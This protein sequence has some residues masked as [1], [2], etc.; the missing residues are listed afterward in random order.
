MNEK[1]LH[2]PFLILTIAI[3]MAFLL[4][5]MA[6]KSMFFDGITYA[7]I[8]RNLANGEGTFWFLRYTDSFDAQFHLQPPLAMGILA[9]FYRILG[10][11]F[12]VEKIYSLLTFLISA[13][14]IMKIW[15]K[16]FEKDDKYRPFSW[17]PLLLWG[18]SP[19]VSW[20]FR[21][22]MLENT[23]SIFTLFSVLAILYS[24]DLQTNKKYF[25]LFWAALGIFCGVLSKGLVALFPLATVGI[26]YFTQNNSK[27]K[28]TFLQMSFATL[29]LLIGFCVLFLLLFK[30]S[31]DAAKSLALYQE[32][33]KMMLNEKTVKSHFF[34]LNRLWQEVLPATSLFLMLFFFYFRQKIGISALKN[35][36]PNALFFLLI[37]FS[38]SLPIMIS[39]RQS[40]YYILPSIP[41]FSLTISVLCVPMLS[42]FWQKITEKMQ[43]NVLIFSIIIG[44]CVLV[45]SAT[46]I[47]KIGKDQEVMADA[48]ILAKFFPKH[49]IIKTCYQLETDY[50]LRAYLARYHS[51]SLNSNIYHELPKYVLLPSNEGCS[52]I[53]M[54]M[55]A[56]I[57][58]HLKLY[59]L[60]QLK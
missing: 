54:E 6:Q 37:G 5:T 4:P 27:T 19:V 59:K 50:V 21:N 44:I 15:Q 45:F 46:Q 10:D 22:N 3:I 7:T 58:L 9:I 49:T 29:I 14:F 17:F 33:V 28:M 20:C 30:L 36:L 41:Y 56:E 23:V 52:V 18:I 12:Y 32:K 16:I 11:S 31:P 26:Y 38:A 51:L 2:F 24:V 43:K 57:P 47:G 25:W 60:Y 48:A 35:Q 42:H 55:Y 8:A 39:L 53:G 40:H 34:I 1:K 13:F